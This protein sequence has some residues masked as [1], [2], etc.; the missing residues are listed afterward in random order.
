MHDN[1]LLTIIVNSFMPPLCMFPINAFI[2]HIPLNAVDL[3]YFF[4]SPK[5]NGKKLK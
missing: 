1:Y 2:L 4:N 3:K 5:S